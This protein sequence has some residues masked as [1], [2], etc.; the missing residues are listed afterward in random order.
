MKRESYERRER[1]NLNR[2]AENEL[3]KGTES[4]VTINDRV[5]KIVGC[6]IKSYRF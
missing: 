1:E 3:E 5:K 6:Y 2:N 4:E